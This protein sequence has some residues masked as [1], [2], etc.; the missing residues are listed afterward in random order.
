GFAVVADEV[1]ALASRTAES[2]EQIHSLIANLQQAAQSTVDT[3]Q[4]GNEQAE[5]GVAQ[6]AEADEALEGIRQAIERIN[7]MAGQIASAAEEQSS[8]AEE[9]NRN[10]TN[11][12][13]LAD[14]TEKQASRSAE[15]SG[16]L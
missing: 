11:I 1:R 6:V 5:R 16:E 3:M 4:A 15:L 14:S 10:V 12:A 9:I 7:E 8:V 2:T 13:T